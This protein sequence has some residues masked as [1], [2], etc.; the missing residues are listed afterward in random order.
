MTCCASRMAPSPASLLVPVAAAVAPAT[1]LAAVFVAVLVAVLVAVPAV[2]AASAAIWAIRW[3]G[4]SIQLW[5]DLG[6]SHILL[7]KLGVVPN[8]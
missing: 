7:R 1:A 3:V 2:A 8:E 5:E 4:R 6:K